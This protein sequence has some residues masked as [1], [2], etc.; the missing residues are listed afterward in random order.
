MTKQNDLGSPSANKVSTY[1]QNTDRMPDTTFHTKGMLRKLLYFIWEE[2]LKAKKDYE[3][4][5]ENEIGLREEILRLRRQRTEDLLSLSEKNKIIT[6]Q[7]DEIID[8]CQKLTG[9]L[10]HMMVV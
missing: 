10:A 6:Q 9:G 8:L 2:K 7:K 1:Q 4:V 5:L 3:M